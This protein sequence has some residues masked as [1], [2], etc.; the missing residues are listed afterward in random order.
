MAVTSRRKPRG[1]YDLPPAHLMSRRDEGSMSPRQPRLTASEDV[2]R[3]NLQMLMDEHQD[4]QTKIAAVLGVDKS[5]VGKYLKGQRRLHS[6]DRLDKLA[7]YYQI[8]PSQLLMKGAPTNLT[9]DEWARVQAVVQL[10]RK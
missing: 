5:W 9:E 1:I 6:L 10:L 2:V 3:A 8:W 4:S 7:A